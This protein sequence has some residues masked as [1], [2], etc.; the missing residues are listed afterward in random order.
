MVRFDSI[1]WHNYN[2]S[3]ETI[4]KVERS[5]R[6]LSEQESL[7]KVE[8][9]TS[10]SLMKTFKIM[11]LIFVLFQFFR[12]HFLFL[13]RIPWHVEGAYIRMVL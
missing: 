6:S 10:T 2:C 12:I 13:C 1:E 3:S 9:L 8:P 11:V 4:Y 7:S 5:S